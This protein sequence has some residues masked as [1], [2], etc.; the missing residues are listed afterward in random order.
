MTRDPV[1]GMNVD[2]QHAAAKT[3]YQGT[4]YY[5]CSSGCQKAFAAEPAKY[6]KPQAAGPQPGGGKGHGR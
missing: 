2:E 4:M 6:A 1:C 5:F 3:Q